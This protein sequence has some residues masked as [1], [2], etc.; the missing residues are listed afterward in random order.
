M[1]TSV[2]SGCWAMRCCQ[3]LCAF[4]KVLKAQ[5]QQQQQQQRRCATVPLSGGAQP[6][7]ADRPAM[8]VCVSGEQVRVLLHWRLHQVAWLRMAGHT[9]NSSTRLAA[10]R[11]IATI[12][13]AV[14]HTVICPVTFAHHRIQPAVTLNLN[15]CKLPLEPNITPCAKH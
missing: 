2:F 12:R 8:A 4:D 10:H 6:P 3:R 11:R 14:K 13:H 5:Q 9:L 15:P 7:P 1:R